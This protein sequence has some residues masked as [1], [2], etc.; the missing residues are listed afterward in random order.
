MTAMATGWFG[1]S[2]CIFSSTVLLLGLLAVRNALPFR[3]VTYDGLPD[4]D[5]EVY[6]CFHGT[7]HDNAAILVL[8]VH[9]P[10]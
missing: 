7:R 4:I 2:C 6:L 9:G 10:M 8:M 5:D 1:L 3:A